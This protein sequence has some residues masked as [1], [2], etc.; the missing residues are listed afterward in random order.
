MIHF[1]TA[2]HVLLCPNEY[3]VD[4]FLQSQLALEWWL[5]EVDMLAF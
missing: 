3:M 5:E 1:E 2:E 4:V